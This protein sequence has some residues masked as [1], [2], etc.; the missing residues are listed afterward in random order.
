MNT[1][2]TRALLW[3]QTLYITITA[4]WPLVHISS[5]IWVTGPKTDIWLVKTVSVLLLSIA[6]CMFLC[7]YLKYYI[8]GGAMALTTAIGLGF[9]DFYYTASGTIMNVYAVDGVLQV[10]FI[11]AW[12]L[13]DKNRP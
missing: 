7:L 3:I 13:A 1:T 8:V 9:I 6:F 10:L 12:L 5:F 2:P 11:I 4:L